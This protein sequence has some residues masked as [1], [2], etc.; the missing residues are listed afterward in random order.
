MLKIILHKK[1]MM[2]KFF[3]LKYFNFNYFYFILLIN[4]I[5]INMHAHIDKFNRIVTKLSQVRKTFN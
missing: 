3:F 2:T 1:N 4:Y 5:Y